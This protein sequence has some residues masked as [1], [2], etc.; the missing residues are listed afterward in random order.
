MRRDN[1]TQ[2]ANAPTCARHFSAAIV[3]VLPDGK[4]GSRAPAH[5]HGRGMA[6]HAWGAEMVSER[7]EEGSVWSEGESCTPSRHLSLPALWEPGRMPRTKPTSLRGIICTTNR[8][9]QTKEQVESPEPEN[10]YETVVF[11]ACCD[12]CRGWAGA[13]PTHTAPG[14]RAPAAQK[15]QRGHRHECVTCRPDSHRTKACRRATCGPARCPAMYSRNAH[16]YWVYVRQQYDRAV[17]ASLMIFSGWTA[18]RTW[19]AL[20]GRERA[21]N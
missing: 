17:P 9:P 6:R 14:L 15:Q 8:P 13:M 18:S 11:G 21:D 4:R 1:F 7:R 20:C 2:E 19:T 16:T 5:R 12:D 3:G 10:Q